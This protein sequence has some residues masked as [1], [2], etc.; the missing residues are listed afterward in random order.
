MGNTCYI[1]SVIQVLHKIPEL[2]RAVLMHKSSTPPTEGDNLVK[3]IASVFIKLDLNGESFKPSEFLV[4]FFTKYPHFAE[5]EEGKESAF[6]QQDADEAIQLLLRDLE[7][8][9]KPPTLL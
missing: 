4:G 2:K 9:L 3:A 5:R 7:A 8:T 1:N 6:K